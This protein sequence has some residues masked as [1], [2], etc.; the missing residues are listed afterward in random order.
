MALDYT[1]VWFIDFAD[2][3][4]CSDPEFPAG[5]NQ[6]CHNFP[7][8]FRCMCDDGFFIIDQINCIGKTSLISLCV[9][10]CVCVSVGYMVW[11]KTPSCFAPTEPLGGNAAPIVCCSTAVQTFRRQYSYCCY[12]FHLSDQN[13]CIKKCSPL[14][15]V[16]V[17]KLWTL[18]YF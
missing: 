5:C 11:I 13:I 8:S 10:L 3:D 18:C 1:H 14:P 6:K 2:V 9:S 12:F 4:E 16:G 15:A 7:G 17:L